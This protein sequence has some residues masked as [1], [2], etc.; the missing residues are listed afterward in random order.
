MTSSRSFLAQTAAVGIAA[1]ASVQVAQATESWPASNT[2][3][4]ARKASYTLG[5]RIKS[6]IRREENT[7]RLGGVGDCFHVSWE[8]DDR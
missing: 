1:A 3:I 7:L 6:A 4:K 5:P 8:A 2:S